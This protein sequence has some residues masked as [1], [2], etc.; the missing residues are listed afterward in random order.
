MNPFLRDILDQPTALQQALNY[1][2]GKGREDLFAAGDAIRG[3]RRVVLTSMGSAFYSL[4]P[5]YDLLKHWH[6]SVHLE[7]T[8]GLMDGPLQS[9][10]LYLVMSR[11]GESGEIAKFSN[12][13]RSQGKPLIAITMTP[14]S[15]LG[16]NAS[17]LLV[18]PASYDSFICT[19]AYSSLALIGLL[20]GSQAAGTFDFKQAAQ[21]GEMFAWLDAYKLEILAK[22]AA[23]SSLD[24]PLYYLSYGA[25]YGL[26][27]AGAL[28]FQEAARQQAAT[29][30]IDNFLHG[31]VEQVGEH[32]R[33]VWIDLSPSPLSYERFAAAFSR[34][35]RW[36]GVAVG[37]SRADLCLPT[38]D[39]PE[40]YRVLSAA[41]PLQ[42]IAYQTATNLGLEAG[43]LRYLNWV[44][45]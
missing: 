11:S 38:F 17:L 6:P 7:E 45:K 25:G 4:T 20:L 2:L 36:L 15:T 8:A 27:L 24:G 13:L 14:N 42:M 9:D 28:W 22:I 16:G 40:A 35:G 31:P 5:L 32:F 10:T 29:M 34:G 3:A 21:L 18:D 41:M 43:E 44:V 1:T 30:T 39:L 33:G 37:E 23:C 19:K 26:A 12:Q